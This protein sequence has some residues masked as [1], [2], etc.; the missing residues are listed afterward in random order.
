MYS[1]IKNR[2]HV[3][4]KKV[5]FTKK[6]QIIN[7]LNRWIN[8]CREK[9]N[10]ANFFVERNYCIWQTVD[11]I[12]FIFSTRFLHFRKTFGHFYE[13]GLWNV[14][15]H[16]T[17][18]LDPFY[19]QPNTNMTIQTV[20]DEMQEYKY[21]QFIQFNYYQVMNINFK[22]LFFYSYCYPIFL[23]VKIITF[24]TTV[25]LMYFELSRV[26]KI[27][28]NSQE[29]SNYRILGFFTSF[30]MKRTLV[31]KKYDTWYRISCV[32]MSLFDDI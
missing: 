18:V 13:K 31:V 25:E 22:K 29:F 7:E 32:F 14:K 16:Q 21:I 17:L 3:A 24:F 12:Y 4:A 28:L 19:N 11:L 1:R 10:C 6:I 2:T 5:F 26:K 9:I 15:Q 30:Y 8:F 23:F 20:S 27:S